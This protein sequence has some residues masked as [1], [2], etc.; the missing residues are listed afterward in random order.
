MEQN[1]CLKKTKVEGI[2]T[3]VHKLHEVLLKVFNLLNY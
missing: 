1:V 2:I 3:T